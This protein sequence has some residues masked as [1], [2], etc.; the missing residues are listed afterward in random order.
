[1]RTL[2]ELLD[3]EDPALPLVVKSQDVLSREREAR[4]GWNEADAVVL[5]VPVVEVIP[6]W[7]RGTALV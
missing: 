2:E 7:Q 4:C 3:R 5:T 1:M 6:Q